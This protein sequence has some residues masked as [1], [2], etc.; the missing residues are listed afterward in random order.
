MNDLTLYPLTYAQRR[1]WYTVQMYPNS[2]IA[3]L[4][5]TA[6]FHTQIN[7]SLMQEA[8]N[9]V[10]RS[11]DAF[12][13]QMLESESGEPMQA[14][15]PFI[16]Y[17][18]P[19]VD[20]SDAPEP[21]HAAQ[22]WLS[23]H[24]AESFPLLH[25][26][27]YAFT[28]LKL[29]RD[30]YR[31]IF[32]L[33]HLITDGYSLAYTINETMSVY[34]QLLDD[35]DI[36]LEE[37]PSYL[38]YAA[39]EKEYEASDRFAKDRQFWMNAFQTIPAPSDL[40]PFDPFAGSSA[41]KQSR[42]RLDAEL[43]EQ[44]K[45][46]SREQNRS[47]FTLFLALYAVY[48]Q[49]ITAN[50]TVVIG[51]NFTN[52]TNR[53]EKTTMGMFTST[54]PLR[55]ELPSDAGFRS[56]LE[57]V[58][59][60]QMT[61]IRHQRYPFNLIMQH[62]REKDPDLSRIFSI[63]IQYQVIETDYFEALR[64][65]TDYVFSGHEAD[66]LVINIKEWHETG[67]IDI[68]YEFRTDVFTDEDIRVV[69]RR[70]IHILK[71][72]MQNDGIPISEYELCDPAER[73]QLQSFQPNPNPDPIDMT[74]HER[75]ERLAAQDPERIALVF[76][77][78]EWTYGELDRRANRLAHLL[79][80]NGLNP[81][82]RVG[83]L[84]NRSPLM[85]ACILAVWKAGG[86]YIPIDP[87][88][89]AKRVE[90]IVRDAQAALLFT[91]SSQIAGELSDVDA[92]TSVLKLDMLGP[93]IE[94][95]SSAHP[96]VRADLGRLAY[97]IYTSGSTGR[98]KG[99]MVEHMGMMN[100]LLAKV[101]DLRI[102]EHSVIAQNASHCFDISVWQMFA[103]LCTGGKTVIYSNDDVLKPEQFLAQVD[104]DG[105]TV[106]EV[107]PSYLAVMLDVQGKSRLP[108]LRHLI[109][110]GEALKRNVAERWFRQ[111]PHIPLVNAYGP[112]EASD[113][114]THYVMNEA[115]V[116][117]TVPVGRPVRGFRIYIVDRF[118]RM[119]PV[120]VK[121]EIWVSGVGVGRGYLYDP[122]RTA[123]AF[124]EDPFSG[125]PGRRLYKTG[126]LGCWLA[127]G[128]I[129][130]YG[131]I[132]H[133]V[134]VRGYRIELGE[135][136]NTL[137]DHPAVS[138]AVTID[139]AD[140][141]G[142]VSLAAYYT[143][144]QELSPAELK[145]YVAERLPY[146]MI[147]ASIV[148]LEAMPVTPN[149]KIDRKAL[150]KPE[151]AS[152]S[153]D[154]H[155]GAEL[156][157]NEE[158]LA[159]EVWTSVLG[160]PVF[161]ASDHFFEL[162]GD[163]IKAL[164]IA[165]RLQ[166]H[167]WK[168]DMKD[169]FQYPVLAMQAARLTRIGGAAGQQ[170]VEGHIMPSPGQLELLA[171]GP[172]GLPA[173]TYE[174]RELPFAERLEEQHVIQAMD[175]LLRHHDAL[176]VTFRQEN[177]RLVQYNR[178]VSDA[179]RSRDVWYRLDTVE[180]SG[181][182]DSSVVQ[183]KARLARHQSLSS[184]EHDWQEPLIRVLLIHSG[185]GSHLQ[186]Y[187]H[188]LL[189]D[190]KTWQ[191]L[192]SDIRTGL[193]QAILRQPVEFAAKTGA[194][195]DWS[196]SVHNWYEGG[197]QQKELS[198]WR[199]V[200]QSAIAAVSAV[201][202]VSAESAVTAEQ[203]DSA[204]EA[205]VPAMPG[206]G[207]VS[208][209]MLQWSEEETR[210]M[211]AAAS[212]AYGMTLEE[213]LLA[214]LG[215]AL[216]LGT[217]RSRFTV[218]LEGDGREAWSKAGD[219]S[220]T[221]GCFRYSYPHVLDAAHCDE[222]AAFLPQV[223][224][225]LRRVPNRGLGWELYSDIVRRSESTEHRSKLQ[226][227]V[228][229]AFAGEVDSEARA[230]LDGDYRYGSAP[231]MRVYT[232]GGRL[233][234]AASSWPLA[235]NEGSIPLASFTEL[236]RASLAHVTAHCAELGERRRTPSDFGSHGLLPPDFARVQDFLQ[237]K[238]PS[239]EIERLYPM[240]PLQEAMLFY[241]HLHPESEM[242]TE[243][244]V[245]TL[246][247][248]L[249]IEAF[250][251]AV[252]GIVDRYASLRTVFVPAVGSR[253]L[254]LVV[255]SRKAV[256]T[257]MSV[258][259]VPEEE[260]METAMR[261]IAEERANGFDLTRDLPVRYTIVQVGESTWKIAWT[262]HHI[263]MDGWCLSLLMNDL[264][265]LYMQ[266]VHGMPAELEPAVPYERFISWL[267]EQHPHE[268]KAYWKS[269]LEGFEQQTG[270]PKRSG[271]TGLEGYELAE[272]AS[273]LNRETTRKLE[274]L[275]HR[276][277]ATLHQLLQAAW[278]VV[279]A[280]YNQVT[281]VVFGHVVSGR[282]AELSGV[283]RMVGLFINTVPV[284]VRMDRGRPFSDILRSVRDQALATGGRYDHEP[285]TNIQA[286]TDMQQGL[287]DHLLV[288]ENVTVDREELQRAF[289]PAE[290]GFTIGEFASFEQT[291]YD[292]NIIIVP[293]E[294]LL[295]KCNYNALAYEQG[296]IERISGHWFHVLEQI[297]AEPELRLADIRLATDAERQ[298]TVYDFNRTYR[299]Y[300]DNTTLHGWFEEKAAQ[301]PEAIALIC[302]GRSLTYA[303]LNEEANRLA[304]YLK[305]LGA[306]CGDFVG[307]VMER[308]ERL[309]AGLLGI[310][311]AGA[312]YVPFEP[313]FPAGRI[314]HI[315]GTLGIR[316]MVTTSELKPLMDDVAAELQH[317]L[318][319]VRSDKELNSSLPAA[320]LPM[321]ACADDYA[322]AIFTSGSTG[323]PKGVLVR[324]K[325]VLNLIDW[326]L[327]TFGFGPGDRVLFVTSVCFDLSVF[328]IFGMLAAGGSVHIASRTD[329]KEPGLLLELLRTE[330]ITFWDSAPAALGQ[331]V[332]YMERM[333]EPVTD[334]KLRIVFQSG[335]WIPLALPP[336]VKRVFPS[337]QVIAL[338]GATEA[339]VWSNFHEVGEI[340]PAWTSIPYGRPIQNA[341]YYI[342]DGELQ[343]C[344][345]GVP[346]ELYIGGECLA[347]GY[348]D[349][350]LTRASFLPDPFMD[351]PG[352]RMYRTGD[353]AR[354]GEDGVIE[355]L[356]RIDHQVKIHGY[357]IELGEIQVQLSGVE[358]VKD[359]IVVDRK[360]RQ[361]HAVLCAYF[362]AARP[363][364]AKELR[365]A[366]SAVLPAYMIPAYFLQLDKLP[367]TA[368]GKIDRKALP[369][370]LESVR[371]DTVY[372]PP[373]SETER[374]L[375][376]IWE[377]V[378]EIERVGVNDS[379]LELG[380]H[381]LK[382]QML[383]LRIQQAL[384]VDVP[385]REL[386]RRSTV[387]ELAAF[388]DTL[389]R[390][391]H[392]LIPALEA[393]D[394]YELSPAQRR[395]YFIHELDR[396][397]TAYNMPGYLLLEGELDRGR[398]EEALRALFRVHE[399]LR[400]SFA[401]V[402]GV[403]VQR[404][405]EHVEPEFAWFECEEEGLEAIIRDYVQPFDLAEAPLARFAIVRVNERKH[406]LLADMHH[407]VSDGVSVSIVLRHIAELYEGREP[408]PQRVQYKEF[409][410]WQNKRNE[411]PVMELHRDYWLDRFRGELQTAELPTDYSRPAVRSFEGDE[412]SFTA[413][414]ELVRKLMQLSSDTGATLYTV[415]MAAF[416]VL[417]A[418][419]TGQDDI[420]VGTPFAGRA[421]EE[422]DSVVGMFVNTLPIRSVPSAD[423][424]FNDYLME[425]K[426]AVLGAYEHQEYPLEEL[427]DRLQLPRDVSRNPLFDHVFALQNYDVQ[428]LRMGDLS[429]TP[430]ASKS[431]KAKF[432]LTLEAFHDGDRLRF[433]VEYA[434]GLFKRA[435]IRRLSGHFLHVLEQIA[436]NRLLRIGEIE[437]ITEREKAQVLTA[438]NVPMQTEP[439]S[440]SIGELF[441]MQ[442]RAAP[443]R[444]AVSYRG[445]ELTYRELNER[446]N[447]LA[448]TLRERGA[449]PN[450]PVALLFQRSVEMV[451]GILGV[452]KAG[453]AYVPIDPAYPEERIAYMLA[454]S[455]ARL[456]LTHERVVCPALESYDGV[457]LRLDDERTYDADGTD[458]ETIND[459]ND[460]AYI[461]YTSGT[462]GQPKGTRL[463]H[464]N[465]AHIVL[466]TN[467]IDIT[468]EDRVLQFSNYAFDGSVFD[469]FG[470]LLNGA[471]LVMVDADTVRD[472]RLLSGTIRN[473]RITVGLIT[474]ALFHMLVEEE[475]ECLSGM[476]K[477]IFGGEKA[478]LPH[479]RKALD[480]L[481]PDK[482][483]NAYGP[484]ETTILAAFHAVNELKPEA[485]SVP[486]GV[487][488]RGMKLY[489]VDAQ[490][491]LQPVL[492]PGE[493]CIAGRGLGLGYWNKPELTAERFV[494]CPFEPGTVMYRT[495]DLVRWLP[496]GTLE[497]LDRMDQQVKIR[498]FRIEL[499][500]IENRLLA[501]GRVREAAVLAR[502][503]GQ[504][505]TYLCAYY[506]ADAELT[507][508]E[509]RD[510]L[511]RHVPDYM[512]PAQFVQLQRMP[513]T[514]NGKL[515]RKALPEPEAS[516]L[517]ET[518]YAPPRS[519]A[520]RQLAD[521]WSQL[522]GASVGIDDHFFHR[523][524][525][526]IKAIQ[527]SSRL[528]K[529]G[530]QM[531]MKQ[532]FLTP[533]IRHLAPHLKQLRLTASQE[534]VQGDVPL[535]PIQSWFAGQ[536]FTDAHHFNQSVMLYRAEG[537]EAE[538]VFAAW[539][540]L[541][542]HHDA[543]RC[544]F[545][546][547]E[548]TLSAYVQEVRQAQLGWEVVELSGLEP[549]LCG[550]A[551]ERKAEALQT[552]FNLHRGPL[553]RL[554]LFRTAAGDHLLIVIHHL[555]VD[556]VSWRILLD[557]FASLY[558]LA[559]QRKS[560]ELPPKTHSYRDW[561]AAVH[562]WAG[563]EELLGEIPYWLEQ[564]RTALTPLPRVRT[565][566]RSAIGRSSQLV[567]TLSKEHTAALTTAAHRAYR[568]ETNDLLLSALAYAAAAWSGGERIGVW[569]EGHGRE[570]VIAANELDVT[571]T[572][573]WFTALYPVIL[574]AGLELPPGERIKAVKETLR[575]VPHKGIGY[576]ALRF[577]ADRATLNGLSFRLNPEIGFN[578]LGD[579]DAAFAEGSGIGRSVCK[580]GQEISPRMERRYPLDINGWIRD[581]QLT[582]ALD[583]DSSEWA[584][585]AVESFADSFLQQLAALLEHCA[586]KGRSELTPS[587]LSSV[588][589]GQVALEQLYASLP[590]AVELT[591]A[592]TLSPLQEGLLL[593][594]QL[595]PDS[596]AY[597][598]QLTLSLEGGVRADWL[599][600]GLDL[601]IARHDIFRTIFRHDTEQTPLQA[602]LAA[603]TVPKLELVDYSAWTAEEAAAAVASYEQAERKRGFAMDRETPMRVALIR[604]G[605]RSHKLV[606]SFHHVLLDGW[607]LG[608]VLREWFEAYAALG[609][610]RFAEWAAA[611]AP[612]PSYGSY[613]RWLETQNRQTA[614]AYWSDYLSGFDTQ[615]TLPKASV[616]RQNEHDAYGELTFVLDEQTTARLHS[617][618]NRHEVTLSAVF[619]TLWGVLLHKYNDTDD[620][621]FGSVAA[622]RPPELDGVERMVGL[623]INTLPMRVRAEAN[624]TFASLLHNVAEASIR[625]RSY[626]FYPLYEI[627]ASCELK[628]HVFDHVIAFENY[629]LDEAELNN[630]AETGFRVTGADAFE[631][632]HYP[633]AVS[634][635][636]GRELTVR[637]GFRQGVY[638][639]RVLARLAGHLERLIEQVDADAGL[640]VA[641]L[642]IVTD[643]EAAELAK[644]N[645][646]EI[647]QANDVTIHGLFE[648]QVLRTPEAKA[649]T[650]GERVLSF[651][652]LNGRADRLAAVLRERGAVQGELIGLMADRSI[653][654]IAAI[655]G[656]LKSG[657]AYVPI[658]PD[659]PEERI[660]YMLQDSGV[661]L[662]LTERRLLQ[663]DV[664]QSSQAAVLCMDDEGLYESGPA[665]VEHERYA[666]RDSD[667]AYV[668]YT[669]GTTG[670]PKGVMVPHRGMSSLLATFRERLHVTEEDRVL[671]FASLSFDASVWEM[672]MSM[673]TGALL[674]VVPKHILHHPA[675]LE[676]FIQQH[677]I[678]VATLPPTY[679]VQLAPERSSSLRLLITAGSASPSELVKA[680]QPHV[681]YVNAYGPTE[682]TVC[683]TLWDAGAAGAPVPEQ[684]PIGR[685]IAGTQVYI[686]DRHL[687]LVPPGVA[688]ELCIAGEGLAD[689]YLHRPDL[690]AEKFVPHV[691]G[692]G[693]RMYR[694]G[695]LARWLP[696]GQLEYLGR[697]D[698]QVKIRGF[699]IELGE[700]EAQLLQLPGIREAV[701]IDRA[702]SQG[703]SYL[704]A[705]F[706]TEG[707]EPSTAELRRG[708]AS[709]L[710]DYMVPAAIM[711]LD[712]LPLT[713]N[714]KINRSALPE[715][716]LAMSGGSPYAAPRNETERRLAALWSEL[717]DRDVAAIGIDDPFFRLG[718]HSLK[719]SQLAARIHRDMGADMPLKAVFESPTIRELASLIDRGD[720][721]AESGIAPALK[722]AEYPL[723][724]GQKRIFVL[725][726]I[727][728]GQTAYNLPSVYRIEGQVDSDRLE[729][730]FRA[731]LQ[732][733]ESLRTSF[734]VRDGVPMQRVHERVSFRLMRLDG[735]G[736]G[737]TPERL[738]AAMIRPFELQQ[739]PLLRAAVVQNGLETLLF[740]DV[741]HIVTDGISV[742]ILLRELQALYRGDMLP[743]VSLQYKDY[744]VWLSSEE[745]QEKLQ[746]QRSYWLD[747]FAGE[748]PVLELPTDRPRTPA[749]DFA[750]A[751][752]TLAGGPELTDKI[753]RL[754]AETETTVY[755]VLLAAFNV[756]LAKYTSQDDVIVGSPVA[757]RTAAE[758]DEVVG[759]FVGTLA[760]RSA[761]A[762]AKS[763]REFLA[764]V[765][766]DTL[767][768]FTHQD[769]PF[770][771]LVEQLQLERDMSRNPLFD[772]MF[773][774][775]NMDM[776]SMKLGE[777][778]LKP[779]E[780]EH[781]AAKLDVTLE[782][783]HGQGGLQ[784]LW[785]YRTSLFDQ[786]TIER[787]AGHFIRVLEQ[788]TDNPETAIGSI[789]LLTGAEREQLAG[790][791]DERPGDTAA[792]RSIHELFEARAALHP[793][794]TA[795]VFGQERVTY[796][797]LNERANR[798]ARLLLEQGLA[799]ED[800][801]GIML[802]RTPLLAACILAVWKAGG[803]YIP[804]DPDYP[805]NRT[806]GMLGDAGA[807]V[808]LTESV[809]MS[810]E[811]SVQ[812]H[813][814]ALELDR[815]GNMLAEADGS[816]VG[817]PHD[818]DRLAY[819]IYTSGSTGRPKGAMVEHRGMMNHLTAKVEDL[820]VNEHSIIAQNA[821]HC[822]DISVWQLFTSLTLGGQTVIYPN[823]LILRPDDL[824]QSVIADGVTVLE[825]VPSYLA[826]LLD[827]LESS[828]VPLPSLT[829]LVATGEA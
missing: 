424:V 650:D 354:F 63:S 556:G 245:F 530:L 254:Q 536:R 644:F 137:A 349:P 782:A 519:L 581:D 449:A 733:H 620:A 388:V 384:H 820:Q 99:A 328:D 795:L 616:G 474:T 390:T 725:E 591:D 272:R 228:A 55:L 277:G 609:R 513:I 203:A 626:E 7:E 75:F 107:V 61:I 260:R 756:M 422:L 282:P 325:P 182:E 613:I 625:S 635:F 697:I 677:A 759:M 423:K 534:P 515:D 694:T 267:E 62:V 154:E 263:V 351:A 753:V 78:V 159:A 804:I 306:G 29:A 152:R 593:E 77:G 296:V 142:N 309:I 621:V 577:L 271:Y 160:V 598:Q 68:N 570:Q 791:Y 275:A 503:D 656:I 770:E 115:P 53:K 289:N 43:R 783:S 614:A 100:H 145:A 452:L 489:V 517:R 595:N 200:E 660:A 238:L 798:I 41:A 803:A 290:I 177:G 46:F 257:A 292:L 276:Y 739:A 338:G 488:V 15:S 632:S 412:L 60:Q 740:I 190:E 531:E 240:T 381:S 821:S 681:R 586:G 815:L 324:H 262:H 623:F 460:A 198:Y 212:A 634:V 718:G 551:I 249:N 211:L 226:P 27:L 380:G 464:D 76:E 111:Y 703:I 572:V 511:G 446:S 20:L 81:E 369:D 533:T 352:A 500:E 64:N 826:V 331:L 580:T 383:M 114:I 685:P 365:E 118:G 716:E 661:K 508:A 647:P 225:E 789:C 138:E 416:H 767:D 323:T 251:A 391:E 345:I 793:E 393:R 425:M 805:A 405:H 501:L 370:P 122:D 106:L 596:E 761:P 523:G 1:I 300:R 92:W 797:E 462:T 618:A 305:R 605:D 615:T 164:K 50:D 445:E 702:D 376:A 298:L 273:R 663:R 547:R 279:L 401:L 218:M 268:A 687:K 824:L 778:P 58:H 594:A 768:A 209:M 386:L 478:S 482:L 25:A 507:A 414:A 566:S 411:H 189:V 241:K 167:G 169:V 529:L 394:G 476:R 57:D 639:Q 585:G 163:S 148:A 398:L 691:P 502:K 59:R 527:V 320:N 774:Y 389:G 643:A 673:L 453:A 737:M 710:P 439:G 51:T 42:Y 458:L 812:L 599:E 715:P 165:A 126:D 784:F 481:G 806:A 497:Y 346:G 10:I 455:G 94:A 220:R 727:E 720:R 603:R 592:Y 457:P 204:L 72:A 648:Q 359:V 552:G 495:G 636:P 587:D 654:T 371:S 637:I 67:E 420:V 565:S 255:K 23:R 799:K 350:E 773:V 69:H 378:L 312:A 407:I 606:W 216:K 409:A 750:G 575:S 780:F 738:A 173:V 121:G 672:F 701:V 95:M 678:T 318:T 667:P 448:R 450:T 372:E 229:F 427:L 699:R 214:A 179:P 128:F 151:P 435:T 150:P 746:K 548:E 505:H 406:V 402:D 307:M 451:V 498:G 682:S 280:K 796:G 253:P 96:G 84:L 747:R 141:Q 171:G 14:L 339:A 564:E 54:T 470:A 468:A 674:F 321:Q 47:M 792:E 601:L 447:R 692:G 194:F 827:H 485:Q 432:D 790:F 484:T 375:A 510:D 588:R 157:T 781:R 108:N 559:V 766:R 404:I 170:S 568:T 758:L 281:D 619:Q 726:Q 239:A 684:I 638:E 539:S 403:P 665:Y 65:E 676:S 176:R 818:P 695:D 630:A 26:P 567:V 757:G 520:E 134:K 537:F 34:T 723:S 18:L 744:S 199:A 514:A 32:K 704:C 98:P 823:E 5:A 645:D 752:I 348:H 786:A 410:A 135:I 140:A 120:G 473:E 86:A 708:L 584:E 659:Y 87:A 123:A 102:T 364:E 284:R 696:D 131:R 247:G 760:L 573:G 35:S 764:E 217:G 816:N 109:S 232:A 602:V 794:R 360:D 373:A 110:T 743:E 538:A 139:Y 483:I 45:A 24:A 465:V 256:G 265:R 641:A 690:T 724:P 224:E 721:L 466:D 675:H 219:V 396:S 610:N 471:A 196:N 21:E 438:F 454:D 144:M 288:L 382:A 248:I 600:Q 368:N 336:A 269:A 545:H 730:A 755:M 558:D 629:P 315:C 554:A 40:K 627:Q 266:A 188:R 313:D 442:V 19:T 769:F 670:R 344:P 430:Y 655:L 521:I 633:L 168:L 132:D 93:D 689:G 206:S 334:S 433:Q 597:F 657:C 124:G 553:V 6:S 560:L 8:V 512:I 461:I 184:I 185:Q 571:R 472:L 2:P 208:P 82:D 777:W 582:F 314:A 235:A 608:I 622:G 311:K 293:G 80:S 363:I 117:E 105:V 408:A 813:C 440:R 299:T 526:S 779:C 569:L 222:L 532:L 496:D 686:V 129:E 30:R 322:Y 810:E 822:F 91:E 506:V 187:I 113:D 264:F 528:H 492:V 535:G 825:V 666:V 741:H 706:T 562:S 431:R 518:A 133:Q 664:V 788:M 85:A 181:I 444:I 429:V 83:I 175:A 285:L 16:P 355:F 242:Y 143:S 550:Q 195:R 683:A 709:K 278:A 463:T 612:A 646:S 22:D 326:A 467:Y 49:Q 4:M 787:M 544:V 116:Y 652:E 155:I 443:D 487:P 291:N 542:E 688:G 540:K 604:T 103:A 252:Q 734:I 640:P 800:R 469:L 317:P 329:V 624:S 71:Q 36:P 392:E 104:R 192:L 343:P 719:A 712:K 817:L 576:G 480:F 397:S 112:T 504:G 494:P 236:F 745:Q 37:K 183:E 751:R 525:D 174:Y 808:L 722:Q 607:C 707:E 319:V 38:N 11:N 101:E 561:A 12:R 486:I 127:D 400:T 244:L 332:P 611:L 303:E 97:V 270:V 385:L 555:V 88:Y 361:G 731:I 202:G 213:L 246:E 166:Q 671:L 419:Q 73:V 66:D 717:L 17:E 658:D 310:L 729:S 366:L 541:L 557:D 705:Y 543:L 156:R 714:G 205:V 475:I 399:S 579:L 490:M 811:L 434:A 119:C 765:K 180:M 330:P 762:G 161:S 215:L 456:V 301:Q 367:V 162:G 578:Y 669:S 274:R 493:L 549:G 308:S 52:R 395:L 283:D 297:A 590:A 679:A 130:F 775:Q 172:N 186:L 327:R 230:V 316:V 809:F 802:H 413:E 259:H 197:M 680:W 158:K 415:L 191:L 772:V 583:Y 294:E 234:A 516:G 742:Q 418:K 828:P 207:T 417:L 617:I 89:P 221:S 574:P 749:Q 732:R 356:G 628:Q 387:R 379:F 522:L 829:V 735:E 459:V 340:D 662:L 28:L 31:L 333:E 79:L 807:A 421:H 146:Y 44:V 377:E 589:I 748:L 563:S 668:I 362:T 237:E 337:A 48:V 441:E 436:A 13:L 56:L 125:E 499:S 342:L 698:H 763:V 700:I 70:V 711:Q 210:R 302:E 231:A 524:G 426:E 771:E 261:I 304:H 153:R 713:P 479:I 374:L 428:A 776:A 509:L 546:E 736:G 223:K 9:R 693:R 651:A 286:L 243:Q 201:H 227:D 785:E 33:H 437:L 754:A 649:V 353:R 814:T 728:G 3:N 149:G 801:V 178:G 258:M 74:F 335:D 347:A 250:H 233:E 147:P 295:V 653:D 358:H 193:M 90:Q 341:Y 287:I 491:A 357:R 136:D 642:S 819:V 631:R 477:I 39:S